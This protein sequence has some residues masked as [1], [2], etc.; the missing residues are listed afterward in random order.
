MEAGKVNPDLNNRTVTQFFSI[1]V[2]WIYGYICRRYGEHTVEY[3]VE[4]IVE[5]TVEC[6]IEYTAG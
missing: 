5:C 2:F 4:Y 3:I 6:T 1:L